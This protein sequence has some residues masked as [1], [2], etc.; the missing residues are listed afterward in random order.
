MRCWD[1]RAS[2]SVS[3]CSCLVADWQIAKTLA[4]VDC[5][6]CGAIVAAIRLQIE[7]EAFR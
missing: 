4:E 3:L 2:G 6:S 7:M 5:P 1:V